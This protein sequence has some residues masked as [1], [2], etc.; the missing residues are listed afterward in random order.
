MKNKITEEEIFK[1]Y[2]ALYKEK[3]LPMQ[4][5]CMFLGLEVPESWLPVIDM[6]S[7]VLT[8]TSRRYTY[9]EN[10]DGYY[11]PVFIAKQFKS[12]FNELRFYYRV[13]LDI[14]GEMTEE[15]KQDAVSKA[16]KYADGAIAMA[17]VMIRRLESEH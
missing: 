10:G 15:E 14:G 1:K 5:T 13:E 3:D 16:F 17:G 4:E 9:T 2:P 12:K 11:R 6:L 8:Y 7:E